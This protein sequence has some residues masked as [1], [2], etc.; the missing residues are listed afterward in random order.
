LIF[1]TQE[2]KFDFIAFPWLIFGQ[3]HLKKPSDE[4]MRN[5]LIENLIKAMQ[6]LDEEINK[7]LQESKWPDFCTFLPEK[8]NVEFN[9]TLAGYDE[10]QKYC[11][12]RAVFPI[13][14]S[15]Q[16]FNQQIT[17][18]VLKGKIRD[19]ALK[20][21]RNQEGCLLD[22]HLINNV[23]GLNFLK[24]LDGNNYMIDYL[25]FVKGIDSYQIYLTTYYV[26]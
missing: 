2:I 12:D 17:K 7:D 9:A 22:K 15:N 10:W 3:V 13:E 4:N 21:L 6:L 26:K 18:E 20:P 25:G 8:P 24:T 14:I 16:E 11:H 1:Y 23:T 5:T 19:P